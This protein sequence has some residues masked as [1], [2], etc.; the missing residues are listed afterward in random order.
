MPAFVS[1]LKHSDEE[2]R[3]FAAWAL[4]EIGSDAAEAAFIAALKDES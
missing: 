4:D 2:V 3:G 1:A